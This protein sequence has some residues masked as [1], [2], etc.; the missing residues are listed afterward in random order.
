MGKI[1][2]YYGFLMV[3]LCFFCA[4][5]AQGHNKR[6]LEACAGYG[7]LIAFAVSTIG[8]VMVLMGK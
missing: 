5:Y 2:T 7:S 6:L 8:L 3:F 1:V 4:E